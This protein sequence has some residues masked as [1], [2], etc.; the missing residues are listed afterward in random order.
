V[1]F[2]KNCGLQIFWLDE[3][4]TRMKITPTNGEKGTMIP[5]YVLSSLF[6]PV[7]DLTKKFATRMS[8]VVIV[9]LGYGLMYV[10]GL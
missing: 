9:T 10:A 5:I 8:F 1:T 2:W 4:N 3:E 7:Y 6:M